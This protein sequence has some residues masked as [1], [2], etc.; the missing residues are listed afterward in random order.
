MAEKP[1]PSGEVKA[2]LAWPKKSK[3]GYLH[4]IDPGGNRAVIPVTKGE[5]YETEERGPVWHIEVNG[6]QATV[7]PSIHFV[8]HFH[9]PNPV[10]FKLVRSLPRV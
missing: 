1:W 3:E 2:K 4:F 9:S 8:G 10:H 7:S 6:K 5:T